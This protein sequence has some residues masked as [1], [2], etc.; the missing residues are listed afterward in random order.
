MPDHINSSGHLAHFGQLIRN[1]RIAAGL[2]QVELAE[3]VGTRQATISDLE[4]GQLN[5]HLDLALTLMEYLG[6]EIKTVATSDNA[7]KISDDALNVPDI[8]EIMPFSS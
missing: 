6:I 5:I 3:M 1:A 2:R 4:R 8:D 7:E